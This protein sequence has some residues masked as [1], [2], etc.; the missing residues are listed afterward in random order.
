MTLLSNETFTVSRT[1]AISWA[2]LVQGKDLPPCRTP[3]KARGFIHM[4]FAIVA[5]ELYQRPGVDQFGGNLAYRPAPLVI[6]RLPQSLASG[7]NFPQQ[8]GNHPETT[9]VTMPESVKST[10]KMQV[11]DCSPPVLPRRL[12]TGRHHPERDG[13][14]QR[15]SGQLVGSWMRMRAMCSITRAFHPTAHRGSQTATGR[16]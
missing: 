15:A 14:K 11:V 13:A 5:R 8:I 2:A 7:K 16:Q 10:K 6:K 9:T 12:R 1:T 3:S 4:I